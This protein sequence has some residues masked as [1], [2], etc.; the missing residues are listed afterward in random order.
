MTWKCNCY[1]C[2]FA[3]P[4]PGLPDEPGYQDTYRCDLSGRYVGVDEVPEHC[5]VYVRNTDFDIDWE[6]LTRPAEDQWMEK[7]TDA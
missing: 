4:I 6:E 3:K 1:T 5:E 7:E 2:A